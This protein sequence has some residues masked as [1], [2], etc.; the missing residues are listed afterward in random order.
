MVKVSL[1]LSVATATAIALGVGCSSTASEPSESSGAELAA[2]PSGLVITQV[3]AGG[4]LKGATFGHDYVEIF[5]RGSW[6]VNLDGI[7]LQIADSGAVFDAVRLIKLPSKTLVAGKYFL[8]QLGGEAGATDGPALP[9]PEH[10]SEIGMTAPSGKVALVRTPL[11]GCGSEDAPCRPGLALSMVSYGGA[12]A[13]L[14]E[15]DGRTAAKRKD[16]CV[17][18]GSDENDFELGEP[19]PRNGVPAAVPCAPA[20][21]PVIDGGASLV[22]LNEVKVAAQGG[23]MGSLWGYAEILCTPRA[24]LAGHYF[25][26]TDATGLATLVIDLGKR[27]CGANGLVYIKASGADQGHRA[28]ESQTI[29]MPELGIPDAGAALTTTS[30]AALM[31]VKSPVAIP[32]GTDFDGDE[33][34]TPDLPANA[35]IVD[36]I[37]IGEAGARLPAYVPKFEQPA[38]S[39]AAATRLVSDKRPLSAAA[40]FGG[41]LKGGP[42]SKDYDPAKLSANAPKNPVLTPGK[43]NFTA[44]AE[45]PPPPNGNDGG[46]PDG[47]DTGT[48]TTTE[49]SATEPAPPAA[50]GPGLRSADSVCSAT[51]GP[52]QPGFAAFAVLG[53]ALAAVRRRSTRRF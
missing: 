33:N 32:P 13:G 31:I 47:G 53:L 22:L 49:T 5:N 8:V 43:V 25:V 1:F 51:P 38:G 3:F 11:T 9:T 40:W 37:A 35:T 30:N 50:P 12:G 4:G 44:A 27:N 26:A 7:A 46:A 24:S 42:E 34:G 14:G 52:S 28:E 48:T 20:P 16:S 23:M 21:P 39:A 10:V 36:G 19:K 15:L 17:D 41:A 29:V 45:P 18:T 2:N 6:A